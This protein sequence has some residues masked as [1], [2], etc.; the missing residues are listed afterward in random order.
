MGKTL[1]GIGAKPK[2]RGKG[3]LIILHFAGVERLKAIKSD[4]RN[5]GTTVSVASKHTHKNWLL[6]HLSRSTKFAP[7]KKLDS[8]M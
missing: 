4:V 3:H 6:I 8:Q 1:E 7:R 2:T 5:I